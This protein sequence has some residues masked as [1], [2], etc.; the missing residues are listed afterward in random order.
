MESFE[1]F[2]WFVALFT[3]VWVVKSMVHASM[4]AKPGPV[5]RLA[6]F[7]PLNVLLYPDVLTDKGKKLRRQFFLS[8]F[9]F[10]LNVGLMLF[11]FAE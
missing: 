10:I 6:S 7:N 4:N 2:M 9:M 3:W 5:P 1:I 11:L 8:A